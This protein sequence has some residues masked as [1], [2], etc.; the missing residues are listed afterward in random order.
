MTSIAA[1]TRKQACRRELERLIP[2]S[3]RSH[4]YSGDGQGTELARP[5]CRQSDGIDKNAVAKNF[6]KAMKE[7]LALARSKDADYL[8]CWCGPTRRPPDRR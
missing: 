7:A 2:V 5:G 6:N 4:R 8:P 3:S 1:S